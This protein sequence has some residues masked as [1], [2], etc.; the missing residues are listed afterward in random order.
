MFDVLHFEGPLA[1]YTL[2]R[3]SSHVGG[4]TPRGERIRPTDERDALT[5]LRHAV[6]TETVRRLSN[7]VHEFDVTPTSP[8]YDALEL[9]WLIA[10]KV[11]SGELIL[12]REPI[13]PIAS[14]V[15]ER[16]V[17][18][19]PAPVENEIEEGP[20]PKVEPLTRQ[21]EVL[22]EAAKTGKPFC[23]ACTGKTERVVP[24]SEEDPIVTQAKQA[25]ALK[26]ASKSGAAFCE[27][28][29]KCQPAQPLVTP[30][31]APPTVLAQ[32]KQA[33]ALVQ[34]SAAGKGFCE[35]CRC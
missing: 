21:A 22:R 4:T 8:G 14:D 1:H 26:T 16:S 20:Q 2:R 35:Q 28:C 7:F 23:E 5:I 6:D 12:E 25:E 17:V 10:R 34:A 13:V 18:E 11:V 29:A 15:I 27:A 9:L 19:L 31:E 32:A 33:D 3:W 30:P 24:G